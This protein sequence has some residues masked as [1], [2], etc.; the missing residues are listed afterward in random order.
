VTGDIRVIEDGA[1]RRTRERPPTPPWVWILVGL[2][3]G[4]G[5]AVVFATPSSTDPVPDAVV[6]TVDEFAPVALSDSPVGVAGSVPGFPDAIVAVTRSGRQNLEHLLWPV[7]GN[8]VIRPLPVGAFGDAKFDVT[9]TWLAIST[10][11]PDTGE[12]FLSMGKPASLRP[13]ASD[14]GG[15]A[16][17]DSQSGLL[18]YT[19]VSDEGRQLRVSNAGREPQIVVADIGATGQVATWGDWGWALQDESGLITILNQ[20]GEIRTTQGTVLDSHPDGSILVFD[21][22][23]AGLILLGADG[24]SRTVDIDLSTMGGVSAGAISPDGNSVAV[25]GS[26]GLNVTAIAGDGPEVRVPF[27]SSISKVSW[28]SDSGFV[29][30]PFLSGVIIVN[31]DS[32]ET[33]EMLREHTVIEASVIPLSR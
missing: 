11:V 8:P 32:A 29:V 7:A 19:Q 22:Q 24:T 18:A 31:I 15:F 25:I 21:E 5:F 23:G 2:A 9:G 6:D 33:Y 4:V 30:I 1:D 13:L 17:H 28:S 14:V 26:L 12:T 10:R 16:W 3:I 20:E 27:T